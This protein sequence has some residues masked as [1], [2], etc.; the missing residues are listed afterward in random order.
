MPRN[1]HVLW[2]VLLLSLPARAEWARQSQGLGQQSGF[3]DISAVSATFA[4]MVGTKKTSQDTPVVMITSDGG[5]TWSQRIPAPMTNPLDIHFYTSAW[6]IDD[7]LGFVGGMGEIFTTTDGGNTWTRVGLGGLFAGPVMDIH[8][9][10]PKTGV[11]AANSKGE[12]LRSTDDGATWPVLAQPLPKVSLRRILFVD[13]EHGWVTAGS[14]VIDEETK[15][16]T[17]YKNGALAL[18]TDGGTSW[19]TVFSKEARAVAGVSFADTSHGWIISN[20]MTGPRIEQ[21]TDGGSTWSELALPGKTQV[22]EIKA[23]VDV[24][25]FD[26]CEG[27]LAGNAGPNSAGVLWRTVDGGKTWSEVK[28]RKFLELGKM[29]GFPIEA[30][31]YAFAFVDR[32]IGWA[33]GS[34]E[35]IFRYDASAAAPACGLPSGDGGGTAGDGGGVT[36]DGVAGGSGDGC[37]CVLWGRSCPAPWGGLALLLALALRLRRRSRRRHVI[38]GRRK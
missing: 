38:Y 11:F 18:T 30:S 1:A 9:A 16:I 19:T 32:G 5:K 27:W 7:K 20:A 33:S 36:G 6:F 21:T 10:D 17:G 37:G 26:R 12:V 29:F 22:G 25:F 35:A 31:L 14:S 28:E 4:V 34:Y 3:M 23:L 24:R 8:T 13:A 15:E 2:C